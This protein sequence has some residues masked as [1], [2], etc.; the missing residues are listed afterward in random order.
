[1]RAPL[2]RRGGD[3]ERGGGL[4]H[5]HFAAQPVRT[6]DLPDDH[7]PVA[8]R[9]RHPS[10]WPG[11]SSPCSRAGRPCVIHACGLGPI[12][13][14]RGRLGQRVVVP[15]DLDEPPVARRARIGHHHPVR[16]AAWWSLSVSVESKLTR[17][18]PLRV[19]K[20]GS[21]HAGRSLPSMPLNCFIIFRSCANCLS[22]RLTSCTLVPLPRAMRWR[23]LPLMTL[24]DGCA[25][26]A[27]S[28]G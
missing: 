24:R 27:S 5:V 13:L 25:R 4:G 3:P 8:R 18:H 7:E 19:G 9:R 1:M 21:L 22:S 23:R 15:D 20:P 6:A 26:P 2:A 12:D 11:A 28:S 16:V 17:R 14:H 10:R